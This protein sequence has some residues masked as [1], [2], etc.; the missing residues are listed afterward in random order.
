MD[1]RGTTLN[2]RITYAED[3]LDQARRRIQDGQV[4]R[5]TL[6]LMLA[7]AE[8]HRA[9]EAGIA[10]AR[11]GA[12]SRPWAAWTALGALAL[13]AAVLVMSF[14]SHHQFM[15][16]SDSGRASLPIVRLSAGTGELLRIVTPLEPAAERTVV[17]SRVIHVPVRVPV[18]AQP[19]VLAVPA[20]PPVVAPKPV[21]AE[22]AVAAPARTIAPPAPVQ[23]TAAA[24]APAV[25]PAV[26]LT[27]A[28]VIDMVLAAERSLRRAGNQ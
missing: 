7:E 15:T 17:Q 9:R 5:G 23:P 14:V 2:E 12:E 28:E 22:P 11:P 25:A 6:A 8:L 27:D 3:W 19:A 1:E 10:P 26:L 13:A 18:P 24:P 16:V 20:A 21:A 4:A